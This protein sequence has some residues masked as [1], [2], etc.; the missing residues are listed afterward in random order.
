MKMTT[1]NIW[2]CLM[3]AHTLFWRTI[4]MNPTKYTQAALFRCKICSINMD[5][6][7]KS[8]RCERMDV[9]WWLDRDADL[10]VAEHKIPALVTDYIKPFFRDA[11]GRSWEGTPISETIFFLFVCYQNKNCL[12]FQ[13]WWCFFSPCCRCLQKRE[14]LSQEETVFWKIFVHSDMI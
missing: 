14:T 13:W 7:V 9:G 2:S 10:H 3:Q 11:W 12:L 8:R 1:L 5:D 6:G 4:F